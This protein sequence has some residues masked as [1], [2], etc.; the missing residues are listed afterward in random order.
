M[1]RLRVVALV[2]AF[3]VVCWARAALAFCGFYVTG[4]DAKLTNG[5]TVVVLMRD[6]SHTVLS[7]QN[8]YE[9]PPA[10]FA[11]VVPVPVVLAKDNVRT[12]TA[13]VFDRIDKLAAP[14]LVEYWEQD[15]CA[16]S[17][18]PAAGV[19]M[20]F[21]MG[22][23]RLG[24]AAGGGDLGV[25]VEA[26]FTVGEYEIVILSAEDASGLETWLH[27]SGYKIPEGAGP[28][29]R[30]YV[31]RGTKF[32]VA[33]VDP[34]KVKFDHGAA[35]LSPLRFDYDS[36]TFELPVRL[37]LL[38][39]AGVQDLVVHILAQQRYEVANYDNVAIPTN[40]DVPDSARTAFAATYADIFDRTMA[41]H[42]KAVV[43]EYAWSP[44]T[45]DPCPGPSLTGSDFA[46]L[47]GDVVPS[48]KGATGAGGAPAIRM[49]AVS[50]A[51]PVPD[52][53]V[54]RI[55]RQNF[56]RFRLC[57]E[58]ALR[59]NP[60]L[61]GRVF[62]SFTIDPSGA[63]G[64]VSTTGSDLADTQ[65]VECVRRGF[66]NLS[67][68]NGPKPTKVVFPIQFTLGSSSS[69]ALSRAA[70]GW[71]L[72][73]LHARYGKDALGQDLV[74]RPAPPIT[75]GREVR[76]AE[77]ALEQ[78]AKE[79]TVNNFQARYAIRHPWTGPMTCATPRR[80]VWGGNPGGGEAPILAAQNVAF[81][82]GGAA[83]PPGAAVSATPLGSATPAA[84]SASS[85]SPPS[86]SPTKPGGCAGCAAAGGAGEGLGWL[87]G[88]A[89]AAALAGTAIARRPLSDS[90]RALSR[91]ACP[92]SRGC[93]RRA[94]RGGPPPAGHARAP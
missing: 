20:G 2:V 75:G 39:S 24:G 50:V 34:A 74:F 31:E 62:A 28:V 88:L 77:G 10:D 70:A 37:G 42:P 43:T 64:P 29:L 40:L 69:V 54:Q 57:Y 83:P 52:E 72:T 25:K 14:R 60:G 13:D 84:S 65:A 47:G 8:H 11:M 23:G 59:N 17:E 32:F 30:P 71:V 7:M 38:N 68:P 82:R 58:N 12:L 19:G 21:G 6:G 81:A 36:T 22:H 91:R 33:K 9:G 1:F 90:R 94:A 44:G 78:G 3:V 76:G 16:Q 89:A 26:Q 85:A 51:G 46:T 18:Q 73:R 15:P 49:G 80:N 66:A 93:L 4:A 55:V 67:F 53:V 27:R 48:F 56:G 5:A 45:C 41:Q 87:G 35:M 63:P 61:T 86:P 79:S 92:S